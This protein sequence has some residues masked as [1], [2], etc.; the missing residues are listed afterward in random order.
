MTVPTGNVTFLFT[1]IEGSTRLAQEF[2]E[3]LHDSLEKHHA[4]LQTAIEF[5]KGYVFDIVGDAFC[6]AFQ[7]SGDAI[8][9][10]IEIQKN[11]AN[12]DWSEA[13][14][15]VRI[16]IHTGS[17]EWNG[18]RYMGYITLSR[19]ARVMSAAYGEQI[20]ISNDTY[21]VYSST[22]EQLQQNVD[23]KTLSFRDLGERRLK[24]L[25]QPIRLFQVIS[26]ELREDFP[27]L[28]TLDAR[29]NNLPV[30]LTSYIGM[31]DVISRARELLS[32]INLLTLLGSGG[33]GKTRLALQIGADMIDEFSNGVFIIELAPVSDPT[34]ILQTFMNSLSV[35]EEAGRNPIDTLNDFLSGKDMLIILDN[36]EHLVEECAL[37]TEMILKSH[38]KLKIIATSRE[39]LNC[40][41]EQK[42]KVPSLSVPDTDTNLSPEQLTQFDS[43]R[44]FIERAL[45]VNLNFR[46][47]ENN[48]PALAEICHRLDGIPLAIELAAAR[49]KVMSVEK[50]HARLDDRFNLLTGGK[51]TSLPRQQTLKALIDWSYDLLSDKEK[52]LWSRMSVFSG[53]F[54][55]ES[56]EE[57]CHDEELDRIDIL[58]LLHSLA[59]K[60]VIVYEESSERFRMLDT[61]KQYGYD[62]LKNANEYYKISGNHLN[63]FLN[64]SETA[65]PHLIGSESQTWSGNLEKERGNIETALIRSLPYPEDERGIRLAGSMG[66]FWR[67]RCHYSEGRKWL[68]TFV[69]NSVNPSKHSLA[70]AHMRLGTCLQFQGEIDS[71]IKHCETAAEIYK[72]LND[73]KGITESLSSMAIMRSELGDYDLARKIYEECFEIVGEKGDKSKIAYLLNDLGSSLLETGNYQKAAEMFEESADMQRKAGDKRGIAYSLYNLGSIALEQSEF[74]RGKKIFDECIA[75]FR[76]LEDKRGVA[77]SLISLG[78][79]ASH[80]GDLK[81]SREFIEESISIFRSLGDKRGLTFSLCSLADA[82][83]N[84][85][86]QSNVMELLEESLSIGREAE[87]KPAVAYSLMCMGNARLDMGEIDK[88][89]KLFEESLKLSKEIGHKPGVAFN[90]NYLGIVAMQK[91][92]IKLS[93][94]LFKESFQINKETN[95]RKELI[96]N[97][98]G[99]AEVLSAGDALRQACKLLGYINEFYEST[100]LIKDHKLIYRYNSLT[101]NLKKQTG[102]EIFAECIEE[103][104]KLLPDQ[105]YEIL[106]NELQS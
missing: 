4:I 29:P 13:V 99:I 101:Q 36:C 106:L 91:G 16:G 47:N 60:S 37:F 65:E 98:L 44:L 89:E 105:A 87:I 25:I 77:Y 49:T 76:E 59:D 10:A 104:K 12:E 40:S 72:E 71:A 54:D 58:D 95:Q 88:A 62:K 3:A 45:S 64:F 5:N 38:P 61:I 53:G 86:D 74:D 79:I 31:K 17:A 20:L 34:L 27:P 22:S 84:F 83:L 55:L 11:L 39:A 8:K 21:Q 30:Q 15:K 92:D 96:S 100:N 70:K 90:L 46:I 42:Y 28:K 102:E 82:K 67:L 103:G 33:S 19:T 52:L 97:I 9:A 43:V 93:A 68:E 23:L 69:N 75:I 48:A 32:K 24:D 35:K 14:I 57:I 66:L 7:N 26:S 50:I 1:D 80:T 94:I 2:P 56:A 18:G 73:M 85:G 63:H 81:R 51:R 41:G 78:N 6:S